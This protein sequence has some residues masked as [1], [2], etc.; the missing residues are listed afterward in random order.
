MMKLK[1]KLCDRQLTIGYIPKEKYYILFYNHNMQ[2]ELSVIY[3]YS[4]VSAEAS[5]RAGPA[6]YPT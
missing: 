1:N 3:R 2:K 6:G 4:T 5:G